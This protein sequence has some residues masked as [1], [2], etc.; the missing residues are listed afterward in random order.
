MKKT[1]TAS[2]QDLL[3]AHMR[4]LNTIK[5][6]FHVLNFSLDEDAKL[7]AKTLYNAVTDFLESKYQSHVEAMYPDLIDIY[8][9][10]FSETNDEYLRKANRIKN[11]E[12]IPR[13]KLESMQKLLNQFI[14]PTGVAPIM[15]RDNSEHKKEMTPE[16][17][18]EYM[19]DKLRDFRDLHDGPEDEEGK[20][21]ITINIKRPSHIIQIKTLIRELD[22]Q[23][24]LKIFL[25]VH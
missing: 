4:L 1:G 12:N 2:E 13:K 11:S 14:N 22:W 18:S 15:N 20:K 19:L 16:A 23:Y 21:I 17:V 5:T 3:D 7:F 8:Q 25:K 6:T 9:N 24:M 10:F